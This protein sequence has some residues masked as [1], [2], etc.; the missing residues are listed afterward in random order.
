VRVSKAQNFLREDM[1]ILFENQVNESIELLDN[2]WKSTASFL[3]LPDRSGVSDDWISSAISSFPEKLLQDHFALLTS[4]STG[5]PKMIVGEK[6]RSEALAKVLHEEQQSEPVKQTILMLPLS[7]C[8]AFVNQWLWSR[9]TGH[10]MVVTKGLKQPDETKRQ[11]LKARDAMLCLVGA[12]IPL[13]INH[14]DENLTFPGIIRLHFA[15]GPFPGQHMDHIKRLFP[16]AKIF[17][18]YGCAEAMPRLTIRSLEDSNDSANI[19]RPLPGIALKTGENGEIFFRSPF[20]AVGFYSGGDFYNVNDEQWVSTGD[21]GEVVNGGCWR[22]SGRSNDVY[23][24]FGEK[25]ALPRLL[26]TVF[27]CWDGQAA[28]YRGRDH[29]GEE[30]HVLVMSPEPT[31]KQVRQVLMGFRKNHPR[32]HWP[33]RVESLEIMPLLQNGKI[34]LNNLKNVENKQIHWRQRL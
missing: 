11:L 26:T 25:I 17:N 8:Y 28:F 2:A 12:Q 16:N 29:A 7:Y 4:G 13:L 1:K 22:I 34:D 27:S 5:Q 18:N 30:C 15:G 32:T 21:L 20:R 31:E 3:L 33:L 6:L 14:F 19:G 24:R 10:E 9:V 23:K